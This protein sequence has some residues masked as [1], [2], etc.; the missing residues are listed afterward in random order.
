MVR[1]RRCLPQSGTTAALAGVV[2]V[3]LGCG[4][5]GCGWTA[6]D[7]YRRAQK[8]TL[9]STPGD[10]SLGVFAAEQFPERAPGGTA[11]ATVPDEP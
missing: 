6:R 10:G 5:G 7:E 4:L 9:S 8:V 3:L 11:I 2:A 1:C